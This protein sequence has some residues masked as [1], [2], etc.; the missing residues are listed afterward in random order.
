MRLCYIA[1]ARSPIAQNWIR[2][3]VECGDDVHLVSTYPAD[4]NAIPGAA[5]TVLPLGLSQLSE[6]MRDNSPK[7][8]SVSPKTRL[9][10]SLR[11]AVPFSLGMEIRD[12]SLFVDA[13][14]RK[15]P[16]IGAVIEQFAPDLVHA[17][18]IPFEAMLAA[19]SLPPDV[20]LI[21]SV[22][23]NDFTLYARKNPLFERATRRVLERT[24]ALHCDCE[25]D[26]RIA[27]QWGYDASKP[28]L[29]VPGSG[30]IQE[31][32]FAPGAASSALRAELGIPEDHR[33]IINP[34]GIR[35]YVRND[36]FFQAVALAAQKVERFTVICPNMRDNPA[37]EAK[38]K[39]LKLHDRV[40][41]LP[42]LHQPQLAELFRLADISVSPSFHDGTPNTLLESMACGA[43]PVA[44]DIESVR[45]WITSGENGLLFEVF[46]VAA[47]VDA[48]LEALENDELRARAKPINQALIAA[49]ARYEKSMQSA[50]DFYDR[51]VAHA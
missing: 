28:G 7:T 20:P 42:K 24:T 50:A 48:L 5:L 38:I 15:H 9:L 30:G 13:T 17:M 8:V 18:R 21:T 44:G 33:V 19:A 2:Y 3:F 29:V 45:E 43:F 1:D 41:L 12:F 25:R 51:V 23:G 34:R 40:R 39:A 16:E 27:P 46:S 22:W 4:A 26:L 37:V 31:G 6:N 10:S 36:L 32:I 14:M 49:R 47:Q 35:A 11:R